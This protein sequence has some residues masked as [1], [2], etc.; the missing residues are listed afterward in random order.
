MPR[1]ISKGDYYV[2]DRHDAHYEIGYQM[3]EKTAEYRVKSGGDVYTFLANDAK[4]IAQI[5]MPHPGVWH[6]AE[7][8][9]YFAHYHAF[10]G[11]NYGH[12]FYGYRGE[13]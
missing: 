11:K 4:R 2:F 8:P 10:G 6:A 7:E 5:I 1:P 3:S 9:G 12:I 13:V